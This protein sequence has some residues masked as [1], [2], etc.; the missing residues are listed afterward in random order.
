MYTVSTAAILS[1]IVVVFAQGSQIRSLQ[2]SASQQTV[3]NR[4][5][6]RQMSAIQR[7][8]PNLLAGCINRASTDYTTYIKTH[9]NPQVGINN[10]TSYSLSTTEWEVADTTLKAAQANCK[11]LYGTR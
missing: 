11:E 7:D 10:G 8:N 3:T 2:K 1:L 4:K 6:V 5:L 9:G